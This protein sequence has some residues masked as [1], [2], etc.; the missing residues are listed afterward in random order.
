M[1]RVCL[2]IMPSLYFSSI[3][4]RIVIANLSL[5]FGDLSRA[6]IAS[7]RANGSLGGMSR[8]VYMFFTIWRQPGTSVV[9]IEQPDAPASS[10]LLGSPS[11]YEGRQNI[12][13]S[14]MV[15]CIFLEWP[16]QSTPD[17]LHRSLISLSGIDPGF[18]RSVPP[19]SIKSQLMFF[20]FIILAASM[21]SKTPFS[22]SNR[23]ASM[24]LGLVFF[25]G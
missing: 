23:A 22:L 8:P 25:L 19:T 21:N 4:R 12:S 2:L 5:K 3:S 11:L 24:T 6:S 20:W 9:I 17:F 13:A 18:P 1:A 16:I 7:A 14:N 10:R 15:C